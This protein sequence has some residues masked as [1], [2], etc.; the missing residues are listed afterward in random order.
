MFD[1]N[2]SASESV[3]ERMRRIREA[4]ERAQRDGVSTIDFQLSASLTYS[5]TSSTMS[6]SMQSSMFII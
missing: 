4:L 3:Q 6:S 5:S 1:F 2:Q